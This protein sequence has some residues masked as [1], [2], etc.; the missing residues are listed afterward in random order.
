[1]Y[2]ACWALAYLSSGPN[3]QIQAVIEAAIE[4]DAYTRLVGFLSND[5]NALPYL[6]NLLSSS[7]KDIKKKVS[8]STVK[9]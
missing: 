5:N 7:T 3:N 2:H 4:A 1:M 8:T 6:L 9:E